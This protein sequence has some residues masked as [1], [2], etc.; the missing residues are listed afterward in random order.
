MT[1]TVEQVKAV[2]DIGYYS[3]NMI[4][5]EAAERISAAFGYTLAEL[6]V[7]VE[8]VE[9][10]VDFGRRLETWS[11]GDAVAT[12]HLAEYI[13]DQL[14]PEWDKDRGSCPYGGTGKTVDW[15]TF[16]ALDAIK[17]VID[18]PAM[19]VREKRGPAP[20]HTDPD[21]SQWTTLGGGEL[22]GYE[23]VKRNGDEL[24]DT[25]VLETVLVHPDCPEH[26]E[27]RAYERLVEL[28]NEGR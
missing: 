26:A 10:G 16:T 14:K 4:T 24:G 15:R 7:T 5:A 9:Q 13:A 25:T 18:Y 1:I 19:W 2:R 8:R 12:Y 11:D 6:G 28:A 20:V 23:L 27:Q 17:S 21:G 3:R 22:L